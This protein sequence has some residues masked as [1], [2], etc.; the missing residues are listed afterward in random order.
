MRMEINPTGGV[1]LRDVTGEGAAYI[2]S[3][4]NKFVDPDDHYQ[5]W[6]FSRNYEGTVYITVT[7]YED[8][9]KLVGML[10]HL[11]ENFGLTVSENARYVM[12]AWSMEA[13]IAM[14]QAEA[15][16]QMLQ[17]QN[18]IEKLKHVLREGCEGCENFCH[19]GDCGRCR[20]DGKSLIETPLSPRCAKTDKGGRSYWGERFYPHE[21][22]KYITKR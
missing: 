11:R 4:R 21:G 5:H 7:P 9:K 1:V 13:K 16:A 18:H 3:E 15:Q 22:C 14:Q 19:D 10:N 6:I 20:A 17:F 8:K 12:H 2:D